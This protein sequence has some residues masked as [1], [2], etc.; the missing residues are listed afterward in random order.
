MGRGVR[1]ASQPKGHP[2]V[3]NQAR[4]RQEYGKAQELRISSS[5]GIS[6]GT[7]RTN[8]FFFLFFSSCFCSTR[9]FKDVCCTFALRSHG[10]AFASTC[11]CILLGSEAIEQ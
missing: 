2:E 7:G 9:E 8:A 4:N 3:W 1:H 6:V 5:P 10:A 11:G